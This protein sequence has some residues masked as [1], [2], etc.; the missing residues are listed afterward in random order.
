MPKV[1]LGTKKEPSI[2]L[3]KSSNLIAV[4][5]RSTSSVRSGPVPSPAAAEVQGAELVLAFPEAGV[6]VFRI[7]GE[8]RQRTIA[9]RK[10]ALQMRVSDEAYIG[11]KKHRSL[12][13]IVLEDNV[14][15]FV[16]G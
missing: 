4:R 7:A 3:T 16:A 8:S 2:E 13:S 5:T 9:D 15:I 11:R 1:K 14:L 12:G 10:A 6:E